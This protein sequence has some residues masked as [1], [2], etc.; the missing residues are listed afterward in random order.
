[1]VLMSRASK[2]HI[3]FQGGWALAVGGMIG[4]GIYTLAGVVLGVAGPL[5]WISLLLGS[6]LALVTVRSYFKL[7]LRIDAGGVPV[8]Y[9]FHKGHRNLAGVLSWWLIIVYVLAMGVYAFTFGHY[10]GRALRLSDA[11]IALMI[12]GLVAALVIVNIVGIKEP[13]I[14]QI[15]AVWV[16]LCMLAALAGWGFWHWNPQNL[17]K[18]APDGTLFGVVNGMA[19]TFIAFEGFEMIAYDYRELR[20]P[21]LIMG[22]G[23]AAAVIA[24]GLAYALVTVGAASLVG[25]NV[26]IAQKEN[27][28]AVAGAKAAGTVGLVFVTIAAC[29]SAASAVNATLFSVSR[30]VRSAAEQHLLPALFARCNRQSCPFYAII[31]LG[32][33]STPLAALGSLEMLVEMAS[34]AFLLLFCFVNALAYSETKSH[35]WLCLTGAIATALAAFIVGH[36]LLTTFPWVLGGFLLLCAATAVIF[37]V[38]RPLRKTKH[39]RVRPATPATV[40]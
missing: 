22:K 8:T 14:V 3:T 32:I 27:A 39:R 6:I 31:F 18:G 37:F 1:M 16:E 19:A 12:A 33:V 4:G 21:R 35:D 36:R 20:A 2:R 11:T 25:A 17:I 10:L 34:F 9:L 23:L 5:A 38:T 29:F 28:L 26:L 24:V 7:T 15:T 30:L 40:D 13:A